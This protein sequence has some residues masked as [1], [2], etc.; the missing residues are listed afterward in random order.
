MNNLNFIN[1]LLLLLL[2]S[3]LKFLK[4]RNE[5]IYEGENFKEN[6]LYKLLNKKIGNNT[7]YPLNRL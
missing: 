3:L 6:L 2:I 7:H 5:L 1:L 4:N